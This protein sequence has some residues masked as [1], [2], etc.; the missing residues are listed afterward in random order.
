MKFVSGHLLD[1]TEG[2]IFV[3]GTQ[4]VGADAPAARKACEAWAVR[5][6]PWI[7]TQSNNKLGYRCALSEETV[8]AVALAKMESWRRFEYYANSV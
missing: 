5:L 1:V 2:F 8:T 3:V 4:N 7:C 6:C